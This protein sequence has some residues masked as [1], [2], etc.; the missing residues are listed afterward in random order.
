MGRKIVPLRP[1]QKEGPKHPPKPLTLADIAIT[2]TEGMG[3]WETRHYVSGASLARAVLY[4]RYRHP[5]TMGHDSLNGDVGPI[6]S[7]LR[8]LSYVVFPDA[9]APSED[10]EKDVRYTLSEYLD[11]LAARMN[12]AEG[13]EP[14]RYAVHV[15]PIP[16]EWTK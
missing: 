2:W 5:H 16:E 15:G 3:A 4:L 7:Y 1:A 12:A 8:G 6:P 10:R 11:D 14:A 9:G 13:R